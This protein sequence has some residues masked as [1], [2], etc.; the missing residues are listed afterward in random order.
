MVFTMPLVTY[1]RAS[2][3]VGLRKSFYALKI[4]GWKSSKQNC[5]FPS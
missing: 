1:L 2:D 5:P 4:V 3:L